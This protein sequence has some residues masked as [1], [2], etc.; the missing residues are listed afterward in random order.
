[1]HNKLNVKM[2][3]WHLSLKRLKGMR[4]ALSIMD[5]AIAFGDGTLTL[6]DALNVTGSVHDEALDHLFDDIVQGDVQASFKNT[7]SL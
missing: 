5:Q 4:D 7:I 6:Q 2:K 3:P 1:M